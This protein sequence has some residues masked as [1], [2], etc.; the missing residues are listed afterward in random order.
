MAVLSRMPGKVMIEIPTLF[1][2]ET[3]SIVFADTGPMY[4]EDIQEG[5]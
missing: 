1:T 3:T 2:V 4:L 5:W